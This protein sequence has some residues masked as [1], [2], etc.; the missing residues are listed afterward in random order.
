MNLSLRHKII[1]L[2]ILKRARLS[3]MA[4]M[5]ISKI[6]KRIEHVHRMGHDSLLMQLLYSQLKM[7]HQN[8]GRPQ[9]QFKHVVK[10]NMKWHDWQFKALERQI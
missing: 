5:L 10:R 2:E 6:L 3:S 9:L 1:S 8:Q 4:D 7:G